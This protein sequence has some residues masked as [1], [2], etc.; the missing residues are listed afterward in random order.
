MK[1]TILSFI[2]YLVPIYGY[3]QMIITGVIDGPLIGG[4][5]KAIELYCYEDI[6]DLSI[7]GVG[8]ANNGGGSDGQEFM[9]SGSATAGDIIYITS[10]DASFQTWFGFSA[11]FVN[12]TAANINGDDAVELFKNLS[13]VDVFG[14]INID[15]T[16][17][18]WEYLDGW[19]YRSA[20]TGPDGSTFTIGN[21]LFSGINTLDGETSNA[22]AATPF[23]TGSFMT[24]LPVELSSF[25]HYVIDD[26]VHLTWTTATEQNNFGFNIERKAENAAW[27]KVG[28]AAGK[29]TTTDPQSY[30][31][32]DANLQ[33]G[34][35]KYRLKQVDTD[36]KFEYSNV[37]VVS[38]VSPAAFK[39]A[40][41]YPNP[42]NPLTTIT[43]QIPE[44]Q[45]VR[46]TI[47]DSA[48]QLISTLFEGSLDAGIHES[49]FDAS[50]LASGVYFY[51]LQTTNFSQIR[52]MVLMK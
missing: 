13:V 11:D 1:K 6:A 48:G 35:Y 2:I 51:S 40:Q 37:L 20:N 32:I 14:D 17:Q 12:A 29:G 15:G 27:K 43:Y 7:Y 39:L 9:F 42:F 52:K 28:F 30:H 8:A 21:W 4:Q 19:A 25:A 3:G 24:T 38:V 36:G 46:L 33:R 10:D 26:Q 47:Y 5:P 22:T 16:G 44:S 50:N 49:V 23:P 45:H 18:P 31:Y 34:V 41:N